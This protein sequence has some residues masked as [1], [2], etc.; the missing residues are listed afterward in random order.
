L[1]LQAMDATQWVG[2]GAGNGLPIKT[3][4]IDARAL[5]DKRELGHQNA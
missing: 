1:A 5:L 3:K 4:V 2:S